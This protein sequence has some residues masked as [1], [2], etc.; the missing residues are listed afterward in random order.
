MPNEDKG[1]RPA[2][3][4]RASLPRASSYTKQFLKDWERLSRG[5]RHDLGALKAVMM[6]LGA[7][8]SP[9]PPIYRDH[10]LKGDWADHRECHIG[11]DFLLIYTLDDKKNLIVFVATGTHAELFE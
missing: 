3:T 1:R 11:G 2:S 9:L 8:D 4:K 5:G 10:Q 7:N 6:L